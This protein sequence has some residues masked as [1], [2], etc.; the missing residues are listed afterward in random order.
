[1]RDMNT[2]AQN[3]ARQIK[4]ITQANREHSVTSGAV[5]ESL[6]EMRDVTTQNARGGRDAKTGTD[7]LERYAKDLTLLFGPAGLAHANGRAKR[8]NG[9]N[10]AAS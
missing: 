7:E 10:V 2:A 3:T 4:L 1:M 8:A 6:R 9:R 5:L